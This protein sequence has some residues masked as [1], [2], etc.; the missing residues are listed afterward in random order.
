MRAFLYDTLTQFSPL[1]LRLGGVEGIKD[2]VIPRASETN[3]NADRP[4]LM[5]G[6]GN[7]TSFQLSDSTANDSRADR[8]FFQ[9][10]IHD[11]GGSYVNIDEVFIPLVK[12]ALIGKTS[13]R[14]EII[15]I[16]YLE[17]SQEFTNETY[18]TIFRYLRF[19][20]IRGKATP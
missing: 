6:L 4:F 11:E 7:S 16:G 8:Q 3:I 10:W 12:E 1:Q 13:P 15:T 2:R 18:N 9:V 19:E 14:H 20:A 17:T 5:F